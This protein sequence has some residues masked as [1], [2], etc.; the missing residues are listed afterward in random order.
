MPRHRLILV[1]HAKSS[2]DTPALRDH[3]RPLNRRGYRD[4]RRIGAFLRDSQLLP[5]EVLLST[6]R[7]CVETW[8]G[9]REAAELDV[10]ARIEGSLYHA[11][12]IGMLDTLRT[13]TGDLVLLIGH[14]PGM[15]GLASGLVAEAG[16][17]HADFRR[18]P[19]SA[20]T[21]LDFDIDSWRQVDA[22]TGTFVIFRIPR[23]LRD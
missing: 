2:W 21:V 7:R 10:S 1:R 6:A 15:A 17:I 3:D 14:N 11:G 12:A 22:G 19:T 4:C 13:A 9:I 16:S 5:D 20:T 18:Y 23:E 8:D